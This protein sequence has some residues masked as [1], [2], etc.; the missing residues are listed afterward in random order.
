MDSHTHLEGRSWWRLGREGWRTVLRNAGK[1]FSDDEV[2]NLAAV[3]TLRIVL[4]LVPSLIAG[5]AIAALVIDP[6]DIESFVASAEEFIP[7]SSQEFVTTQ[8]A[9]IIDQLGSGGVGIAGV[10]G[11]LFAASGAAVALMHALNKAY[12]VGEERGFVGK[13]LASLGVIGALVLALAGMFVAIVLGPSLLELLLPAEILDSPLSILITLGRYV[14][15]VGLLILFF[16]FV[17]WFA[18]NRDRPQLRLLTPGAVFGVVGWLLLSY[19]FSIYA[20]V[21]GSYS[22]T[23]GIFAGVIVLL[24]WLNYSFT[25]LLMGAELDSEIERHL[26]RTEPGR[27]DVDHDG[28]GPDGADPDE[29]TDDMARHPGLVGAGVAATA[30]PAAG[31]ASDGHATARGG[32]TSPKLVGAAAHTPGAAL[33]ARLWARVAR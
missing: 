20:R 5:V 19:L 2:S 22:A 25:V 7:D 4:S 3:V 31:E 9:D 8:L 26:R 24:V 16:G 6:G 12:D 21:S 30:G 32:G 27:D 10:L 33:A 17:Y 15:G 28:V 11:G 1:E 29:V 14:V 23:Y 13:R 18:P